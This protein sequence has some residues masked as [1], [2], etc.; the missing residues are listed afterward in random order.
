MLQIH[1]H[2]DRTCR[3]I[4]VTC[5]YFVQAAQREVSDFRYVVQSVTW[6]GHE[7]LVN[8]RGAAAEVEVTAH[9]RDG[10]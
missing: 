7:K 9:L 2:T 10:W 6:Q 8:L 4:L 3:V 5:F 1:R